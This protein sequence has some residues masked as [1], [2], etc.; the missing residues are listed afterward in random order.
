MA[1]ELA[2]AATPGSHLT[3]QARPAI[4]KHVIEL[5]PD[6]NVWH[7]HLDVNK[8]VK[9]ILAGESYYEVQ[10]RRRM[11]GMDELRVRTLR[12]NVSATSGV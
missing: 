3:E 2:L 6:F 11:E 4:F 7:V 1:K 5:T 9:A 8:S 10:E 12:K